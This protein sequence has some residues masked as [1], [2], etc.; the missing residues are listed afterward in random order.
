MKYG[1]EVLTLPLSNFVNLSIQ[2][3]LFPDQCKIAKLKPLYKKV[4]DSGP[5]N[6]RPISLFPDVSKIIKKNILNH[7]QEYLNKNN[8]LHKYQLG[9]CANFSM[10]SCLVKLTD[11]ILRGMYKGFHTGKILVDLQKAF[12]TL[13][14]TKLL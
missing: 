12:E 13:D 4:S 2:Q 3:S 6:Y 9:F 11:L 1:A 14:Y 7:T 10:H 8:L 5:K